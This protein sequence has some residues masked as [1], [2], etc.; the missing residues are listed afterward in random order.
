MERYVSL[1]SLPFNTIIWSMKYKY[2]ACLVKKCGST[3]W[4]DLML[5]THL[6]AEEYQNVVS[7][8]KFRHS[9]L[10][11]PEH[12]LFDRVPPTRLLTNSRMF[13]FSIIRHPWNRVVAAYRDKYLNDCKGRRGC[14]KQ[15][16]VAAVS[17]QGA[18]VSLTET[19][20]ALIKQS[21]RNPIG[22]IHD[23][24]NVNNDHFTPASARCG[25]KKIK[26][27]FVG[28]LDR[29][30]DMEYVLFRINSTL[31][32]ANTS[33][34]VKYKKPSL[35]LPVEC[36]RETVDLARE[37]YATDL[38]ALNATMD[39]AYE[40]CERHGLTHAPQS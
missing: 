17:L 30:E 27:D 39:E 1:V 8:G 11:F 15:K 9:S 19:I 2:V 7:D 12:L 25:L 10:D 21:K 23:A 34:A 26:Y 5:R 18:R 38:A 37:Y 28:D 4:M 3:N 14:F 33:H 6:P 20:Q 36:T 24:K 22:V 16:Y 32:L 29:K 13:K 35:I 31:P 40:A